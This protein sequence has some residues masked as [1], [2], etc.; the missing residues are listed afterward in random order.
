MKKKSLLLLGAIVLSIGC[1][2]AQDDRV[3]VVKSSESKKSRSSKRSIAVEHMNVL[4]FDLLNQLRGEVRF[5]YERVLDDNLSL[6]ITAGPNVSG[7]YNDR[8]FNGSEQELSKVGV[9]AEVGVRYYP[10]E[11][12]SA[13]NRLYI[14]PTIGIKHFNSEFV[15][16]QFG[17]SFDGYNQRIYYT[18]NLGYQSWLSKKVSIDYFVGLGLAMKNEA[19]AYVNQQYDPSTDTFTANWVEQ[20]FRSTGV[21]VNAGVK[22]GVGWTKY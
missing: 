17:Q 13:L 14:S 3:Y 1:S 7:L 4:K 5:S 8:F 12:Y 15:S 16:N 22:I 9:S 11:D 21:Q 18:F 20:K 10:N 2:F 6:E 19:R